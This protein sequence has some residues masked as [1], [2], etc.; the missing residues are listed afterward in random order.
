MPMCILR[1][2][3]TITLITTTKNVSTG[4]IYRSVNV[5]LAI[6]AVKLLAMAIS[7]QQYFIMF[8]KMAKLFVCNVQ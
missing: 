2:H 1:K 4:R 8:I 3:C 7:P 5:P 6:D